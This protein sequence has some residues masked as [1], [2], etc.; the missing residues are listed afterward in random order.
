QNNP[1]NLKVST[2]ALVDCV[3]NP[4]TPSAQINVSQDPEQTLPLFAL[5]DVSNPNESGG[6][7][8]LTI[9]AQV[10]TLVACA[11]MTG[12]LAGAQL[13]GGLALPGEEAAAAFGPPLGYVPAAS[14]AFS[15]TTAVAIA[16]GTVVGSAATIGYVVG[17]ASPALTV[18]Q[19]TVNW[20]G[21]L[22]G[23]VT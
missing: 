6:S 5:F 8:E 2:D 15:G 19:G 20:S 17:G 4:T 13:L 23:T 11:V 16:A 14:A 9:A 3:I 21:G 12:G 22:F 7:K 1:V 10:C 18:D